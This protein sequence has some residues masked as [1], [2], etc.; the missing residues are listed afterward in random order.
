MTRRHKSLIG[1]LLFLGGATSVCAYASRSFAGS[2]CAV[3]LAD[4]SDGY[5]EECDTGGTLVAWAVPFDGGGRLHWDQA[6]G[7]FN[8]STI[9]HA[10]N[11]P[12]LGWE[13][14]LAPNNNLD[15]YFDVE[16]QRWPSSGN[17]TTQTVNVPV[18]VAF[19]GQGPCTAHFFTGV[20]C[21]NGP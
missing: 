6:A 19:D 16:F 1:A 4:Q 14:R 15:H 2:V 11:F 21:A 7:A 12:P 3:L 20:G 17:N 8:G 13:V 5:W 9:T 10:V 18:N